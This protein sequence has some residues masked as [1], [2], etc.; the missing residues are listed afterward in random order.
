MHANHT[1]ET[2]V[3]DIDPKV[4][5]EE[6]DFQTSTSVS[7][8]VRPASC[9]SSA[10]NR[11]RR[12]PPS[13]ASGSRFKGLDEAHVAGIG[14]EYEVVGTL[15]RSGGTAGTDGIVHFNVN[16]QTAHHTNHSHSD[17]HSHNHAGG[18]KRNARERHSRAVVPHG[19]RDILIIRIIYNGDAPA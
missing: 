8:L 3:L 1:D 2:L 6:T 7:L 14:Q 16:F 13:D 10:S 9:A 5:L 11:L 18:N 15:L 19:P 4:V 17:S 12:Q